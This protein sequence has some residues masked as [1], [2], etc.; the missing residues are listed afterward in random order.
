ML[1]LT[2]LIVSPAT[3]IVLGVEYLRMIKLLGNNVG[4]VLID[5]EL[6]VIEEAGL[7]EVLN[8]LVDAVEAILGLSD[9]VGAEITHFVGV[10]GESS[11]EGGF[12]TTRRDQMNV[13]A[14]LLQLED[15]L[16]KLP[17]FQCNVVFFLHVFS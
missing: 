12:M 5:F 17:I 13:L 1:E 7:G 9:H 4:K 3:L 16:V 15:W 2:A 8:Q 10:F 11:W 6:P 14:S